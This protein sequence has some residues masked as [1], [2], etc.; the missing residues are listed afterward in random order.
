MG[1][2]AMIYKIKNPA[3]AGFLLDPYLI[4]VNPSTTAATTVCAAIFPAFRYIVAF[5]FWLTFIAAIAGWIMSVLF[6]IVFPTASLALSS[7]Y[8]PEEGANGEA[9]REF[10]IIVFV[11]PSS[12]FGIAGNCSEYTSQ[13]NGCESI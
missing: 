1:P 3:I 6:Y 10:V 8:S 4:K 2:A 13:S 12:S 7:Q 5:Y 11:T 9:L